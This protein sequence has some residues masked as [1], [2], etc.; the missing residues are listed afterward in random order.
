MND[1]TAI[2]LRLIAEIRDALDVAGVPWWLFGGWAVD[3]HL[4]RV[5]RKH[6]DIEFYIWSVDAER[7][8]RTFLDAGFVPQAIPFPDEAIEFRK[9]GHLICAVLLMDT[10]QGFVIPGRW[11]HWPWLRDAFNGPPGA[12]DGLEAPVVAVEAL[13]DRSLNYEKQAPGRP[14]LRERDVTAIEQ[15]RTI[16][17]SRSV[18]DW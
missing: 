8:S 10:A 14:P 6:G 1:A 15:M 18:D 11:T 2:Q 7:V 13:L 3:F 9:D 5:S 12:I 16:I 4:G 17:A